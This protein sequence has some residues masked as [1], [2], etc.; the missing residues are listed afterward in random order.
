MGSRRRSGRGFTLIELSIV[1]GIASLILALEM[2]AVTRL[3]SLKSNPYEDLKLWFELVCERSFFRREP[4]L[5]EINPREGEFRLVVPVVRND[6]E[7]EWEEVKDPFLPGRIALPDGFRILDV[8]DVAGQKVS[9][10]R[11]LIKV[12]PSGWVDPFT[13]HL[14]ERKDRE[15][16]DHTGFMN[17]FTCTLSWEEG[18]KERIYES[19]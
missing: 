2:P 6:G 19:R 9:D 18:Y 17:P 15:T 4:F 13:L 8:Q 14:E 5:I 3:L 11:T 16:R 10:L 12:L 7:L 1:L